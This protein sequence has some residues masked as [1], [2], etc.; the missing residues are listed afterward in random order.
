[1]PDA[2]NAKLK[3][4]QEVIHVLEGVK[5]LPADFFLQSQLLHP[6][7]DNAPNKESEIL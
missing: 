7:Q 5:H 6:G 4:L 3:F 2:A 1:M